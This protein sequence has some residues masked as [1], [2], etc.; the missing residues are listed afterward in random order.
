VRCRRQTKKTTQRARLSSRIWER[1]S[2][3]ETSRAAR[4]TIA[5]LLRRPLQRTARPSRPR[6]TRLPHRTPPVSFP[7]RAHHTPT[8]VDTSPKVQ[9]Q[10]PPHD[11]Q[12]RR[13][14]D[15]PLCDTFTH[16][17]GRCRRSDFRGPGPCKR[18]R[19]AQNWL[20]EDVWQQEDAW[21]QGDSLLWGA[22]TARW[23]AVLLG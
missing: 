8:R 18:P 16:L 13:W 21:L 11:H 17:G 7:P 14:R 22:S 20:Q 9:R 15:T 19:Q 4:L 23:T 2:V 10:W 1:S 3:V 5:L 12:L 6:P